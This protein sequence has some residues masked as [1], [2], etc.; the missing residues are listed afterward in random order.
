MRSILCELFLFLLATTILLA[1]P[2]K[3]D[4]AKP[5]EVFGVAGQ[6]IESRIA[7]ARGNKDEASMHLQKA[8]AI[9]DTLKYAEPADWYFLC[10][11][12]LAHL[13]L[14]AGK[15]LKRSRSSEKI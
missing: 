15:P 2:Q 14:P 6:V 4:P 7:I 9:Q 5:A 10:A 1:Q 11:N 12:P 3:P 8:V 13:C